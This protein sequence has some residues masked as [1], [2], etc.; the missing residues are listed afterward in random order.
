MKKSHN[1]RTNNDK[2]TLNIRYVPNYIRVRVV[3]MD[4]YVFE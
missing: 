2:T 1:I 3:Q 4:C